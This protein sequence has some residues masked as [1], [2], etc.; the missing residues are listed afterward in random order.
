M[1]SS[2]L[3]PPPPVPDP[4]S[5]TSVGRMVG[6]VHIVQNFCLPM[7]SSRYLSS[8]RPMRGHRFP[9]PQ[10][11]LPISNLLLSLLQTNLTPTLPTYTHT[12]THRFHLPVLEQ[13]CH[14]SF[15]IHNQLLSIELHPSIFGKCT[16]LLFSGFFDHHSLPPPTVF[17]LAYTPLLLEYSHHLSD[18]YRASFPTIYC[19]LQLPSAI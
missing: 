4:S 15:V 12:H 8:S 5:P 7:Y 1:L 13:S 9:G 2:H 18:V 14:Q 10:P 19:C 11:G 3:R 6:D 16:P 17:G